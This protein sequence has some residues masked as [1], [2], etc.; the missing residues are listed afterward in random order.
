MSFSRAQQPELRQ[1]VGLAWVAHCRAEGIKPADRCRGSKRCG[2]CAF[3][4]WYEGELEAATG[5]RSTTDCNAGRDYDFAMAQFEEIWGGSIKWQMKKYSGDAK[6][7]LHELQG[8]A[9]GHQ[10]DEDYLRAAA[11]RSLRMAVAPELHTLSRERLI[12]VMGEVK[13]HLRRRAKRELEAVA[14]PQPF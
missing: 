2:E 7:I 12:M 9:G 3:C 11:K 5:H 14:D 1:L 10:V 6:R 8:V 13:R 4:A